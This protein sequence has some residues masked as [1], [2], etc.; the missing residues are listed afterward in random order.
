MVGGH[1]EACQVQV[2]LLAVL[3]GQQNGQV[4]SPQR[5]VPAV[6]LC[7]SL[8]HVEQPWGP[9]VMAWDL[10]V[11]G[12]LACKHVELYHELRKKWG[13]KDYTFRC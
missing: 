3:D 6:M 13:G 4:M 8:L 12:Y 11:G 7:G 1:C 5:R 9:Y 10:F 2:Q